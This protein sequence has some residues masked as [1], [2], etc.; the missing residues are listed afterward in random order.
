M[1]LYQF[2][3]KHVRIKDIYGNTHIGLAR[4]ANYD[5]LMCEY[6]GDEDGVFIED[7]VIYNSQIESIESVKVHGT[8]EL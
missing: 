1:D 4:Y 5:F 6:G 2:N 7:F 3:E 8:A